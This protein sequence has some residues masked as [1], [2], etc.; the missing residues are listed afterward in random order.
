MS[1]HAAAKPVAVSIDEPEMLNPI[2]RARG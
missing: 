2:A 1:D